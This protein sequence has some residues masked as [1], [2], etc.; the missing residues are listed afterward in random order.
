LKQ[1]LHKTFLDSAVGQETNDKENPGKIDRTLSAADFRN[2]GVDGSIVSR[3]SGETSR[4]H[5]FVDH[6]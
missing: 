1:L 4:R 3:A 2:P 6:Q 5:G